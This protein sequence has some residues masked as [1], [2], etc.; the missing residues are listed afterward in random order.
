LRTGLTKIYEK[1]EL[2][3]RRSKYR[4]CMIALR[5]KIPDWL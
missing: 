1:K 3:L 5:L 4:R 2:G